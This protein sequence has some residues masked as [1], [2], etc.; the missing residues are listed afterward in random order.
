[1]LDAKT[2]AE[3]AAQQPAAETKA[4]DNVVD[5]TFTENKA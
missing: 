4:D 2:A 1:L 5:A 3:Q